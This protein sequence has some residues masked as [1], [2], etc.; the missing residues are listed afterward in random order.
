MTLPREKSPLG[1]RTANCPQARSPGAL[2]L[3]GLLEITFQGLS[4]G[5]QVTD[6]CSLGCVAVMDIGISLIIVPE[7]ILGQCSN[8]LGGFQPTY[9]LSESSQP[10]WLP[11]DI[12]LRVCY[13]ICVVGNNKVGLAAA[14]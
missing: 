13:S 12:F 7:K 6:W 4:V 14:R 10:L 9:L 11:D 8:G 2:W 3:P 5:N 1:A